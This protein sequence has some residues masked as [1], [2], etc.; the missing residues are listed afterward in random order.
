MREAYTKLL[1]DNKIKVTPQRLAIVELMEKNGHIS[2]DDL[3]QQIL[4]SFPTISLATLYKN[5]NSMVATGFVTEV[6][7]NGLKSKY[8]LTKSAH[9]HLICERCKSVE[10]IFIDASTLMQHLADQTNFKATATS[11]QIFGHCSKCQ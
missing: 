2:I 8:E 3:Y 6:K 9:S 10:D 5:L 11:I 4:D 1:R 7:I